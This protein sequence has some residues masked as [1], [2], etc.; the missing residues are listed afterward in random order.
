MSAAKHDFFISYT[1]L[2]N[3]PFAAEQGW[4][5]LLHERLEIRLAQLLG[6][7]PRIWR[8]KKLSGTDNL[9]DAVFTELAAAALLLSVLSPRYF[10]SDWC[11]KELSE[12]HQHISQTQQAKIEGKSRILKVIKTPITREELPAE[13]QGMLG[14]DFYEVDSASGRFREYSTDAGA[15]RDR[16]YWDKLEDLAQDLKDLIE[17]MRKGSAPTVVTPS[18]SKTIYLAETTSDLKEQ[19]DRIRRE[20]QLNGHRVLPEKPLP[21]T[22]EMRDEVRS[23]LR[24]CQLAVHL[25]GAHYGIVPEGETHS[26]AQIQHELAAVQNHTAQILWMPSGLTPTDERQQHFINALLNSGTELLQGK[27]EDLKD[28]IRDKLDP[29]KIVPPPSNGNG[30]RKLVYLCCDQIDYEAVAPIED[31]FYQR[32]FEVISLAGDADSQ[33]HIENLRLCDALLTYCGN[34]TDGWLNLKKMDLFKL[35][36]Y[37]RTKPLLAKAFYISA[38]QTS[39]KER[40]RIQDGLVIKNYGAFSPASLTEFIEQIEKGI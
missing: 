37:G 25:I 13:L 15:N 9:N 20:L 21:L 2:D 35:P 24:D 39:G 18:S 8:D 12:F 7:K 19:H 3:Q 10:K 26:L 5:E 32:G 1:H 29:P 36:G 28:F 14:Y 11:P 27:L 31:L 17:R 38:P 33:L 6:E 40:F 4:I 30:H 16:R 23:L 22:M 34:T